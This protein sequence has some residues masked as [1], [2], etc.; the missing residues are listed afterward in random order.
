VQGHERAL[1]VAE[2]GEELLHELVLPHLV[3]LRLGAEVEGLVARVL[4]EGLLALA[5]A[6]R[7][8]GSR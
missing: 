7:P 5:P 8:K 3:D 6:R 2:A 4:A 1:A